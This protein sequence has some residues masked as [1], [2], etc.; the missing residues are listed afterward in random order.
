MQNVH[1]YLLELWPISMASAAEL[2][3]VLID[4]AVA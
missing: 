3:T 4:F 1:Y 2:L